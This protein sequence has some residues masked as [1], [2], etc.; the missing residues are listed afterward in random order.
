MLTKSD[1]RFGSLALAEHY[2]YGEVD[3]DSIPDAFD[4][5]TQWK[6]CK[7]IQQIRNQVRFYGSPLCMCGET[8]LCCLD[9]NVTFLT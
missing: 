5:R 3:A 1:W 2:Q 8:A 9:R 7:S 4:A 6:D